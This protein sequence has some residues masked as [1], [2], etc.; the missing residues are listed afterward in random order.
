MSEIGFLGYGPD[1][2]CPKCKWVNFAIR[3]KCRNCRYD[4]NC[5]EF[6]WYNPMPPYEGL[7]TGDQKS[8]IIQELEE[9]SGNDS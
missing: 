3:E 4:S 5:G 1:W 2:I 6:P 7:R 8:E 9:R